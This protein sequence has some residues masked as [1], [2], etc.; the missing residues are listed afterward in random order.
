MIGRKEHW[1]VCINPDGSLAATGKTILASL[2]G[3]GSGSLE[4][5]THNTNLPAHQIKP[6]LQELITAGLVAET[7]GAFQITEIG[8]ALLY[9]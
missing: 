3:P 7:Q 4:E 6:C 2:I 1:M 9:T 8:I 5:I